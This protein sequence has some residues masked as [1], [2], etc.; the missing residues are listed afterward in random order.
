MCGVLLII[1]YILKKKNEKT[2]MDRKL[3]FIFIVSQQRMPM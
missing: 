3:Y 2:S 1:K